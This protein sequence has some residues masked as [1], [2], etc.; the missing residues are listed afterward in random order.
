MLNMSPAKKVAFFIFLHYYN[1][2]GLPNLHFAVWE[3]E[4]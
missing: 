4:K 1:F 2:F 3:G